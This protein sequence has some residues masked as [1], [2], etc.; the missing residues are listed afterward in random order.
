[1]G[2]LDPDIGEKRTC[3]EIKKLYKNSM[4]GGT[5]LYTYGWCSHCLGSG[6][7]LAKKFSLTRGNIFA[8]EGSAESLPDSSSL[9]CRDKNCPYCSGKGKKWYDQDGDS[10]YIQRFSS[11]NEFFPSES[12]YLVFRPF[13][14]QHPRDG[15]GWIK[16]EYGVNVSPRKNDGCNHR[17]EFI[18]KG[19]DKKYPMGFYRCLKCGCSGT[20]ENCGDGKIQY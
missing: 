14:S 2:F 8:P 17:W 12:Y 3:S 7:E 4:C 13:S 18:G 11:N 20:E 10:K 1:M 16:N 15:A 19:S 9:Y 5:G 6:K